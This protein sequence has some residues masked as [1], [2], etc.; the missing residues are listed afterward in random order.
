MFAAAP[1]PAG[2][3]SFWA[4]AASRFAHLHKRRRQEER[5]ISSCQAPNKRGTTTFAEASDTCDLPVQQLHLP[6]A[7]WGGGLL[8]LC[9]SSRPV[10]RQARRLPLASSHRMT[11]RLRGRAS[12]ATSGGKPRCHDSS[13][14]IPV[15][16]LTTRTQALAC[17]GG[18]SAPKVSQSFFRLCSTITAFLS[19]LVFSLSRARTHPPGFPVL[20]CS[21]RLTALRF[22]SSTFG[23][24][25][26]SI[27]SPTQ[28]QAGRPTIA[29][30]S[31][32]ALSKALR[33]TVRSATSFSPS[34]V[35]GFDDFWAN[36]SLDNSRAPYALSSTSL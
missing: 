24:L 35:C 18:P 34:F 14:R 15:H 33:I 17:L 31:H 28:T 30:P 20:L 26:V 7:S 2:A 19:H 23:H 13:G 22:A 3:S 32:W 29:R 27:A 8:C 11:L 21:S 6:P 36:D 16:C 12:C 10:D 4:S 9:C 1:A 5:E 25:L